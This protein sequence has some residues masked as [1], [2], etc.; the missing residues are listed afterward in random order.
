MPSRPDS[1]DGSAL[2]ITEQAPT[3]LA[4]S[5]GIYNPATELEALFAH[6]T[7][8]EIENAPAPVV[9]DPDESLTG[10]LETQGSIINH[11]V[12]SPGNSPGI[13]NHTG[14]FTQSGTMQIEI[15]GLTPGPGTPTDNGYDQLNVS[16]MLTLGGTLEIRLIND[17]VPELGDTFEFITAG[18]ISGDFDNFTGMD[19]GDGLYLKPVL[20][21]GT[22][23]LEVAELPGGIVADAGADQDELLAFLAGKSSATAFAF[24]GTI[25][26]SGFLHLS[27]SFALDFFVNESVEVGTGIPQNIGGALQNYP[28]LQAAANAVLA[29]PGVTADANF[30]TISNWQLNI[31]TVGAANVDAFVGFG[32]PDFSQ[33]LEGQTSLVG[34][35]VHDLDIGL[36]FGSTDPPII[37]ALLNFVGVA[38]HAESA[39][40][41]GAGAVSVI[42]ND[43]DLLLNDNHTS[44]PLDVGTAVVNW[45]SSYPDD[46]GDGNDGLAIA[47][48]ELDAQGNEA[49]VYL[50]H[51]GEQRVSV[52][53]GDMRAEIFDFVHLQGSFAFSKGGRQL[54]DITT[55]FQQNTADLAGLILEPVVNA[56]VE[57]SLATRISDTFDLIY[58]WEVESL[59]IGGHGIKAFIGFGD[60]DFDQ[61]LAGQSGLYGAYIDNLELG[62]AL[63][64]S[65]FPIEFEPLRQFVAL[66]ATADS[67][68]FT[69]NGS[70]LLQIEAEGIDLVLNDNFEAWPVLDSPAILNWEESFP[71]GDDSDEDPDGFVIATGA[72]DA[73]GDPV[74]V[75]LDMDGEQRRRVSIEHAVVTL[76]DFVHLEGSIFFEQ[77]PA[78]AATVNTRLPANL[79]PA[80]SL[81]AP[82]FEALELAGFEVEDDLSS[83][84]N[85]DLG[86]LVIGGYD[87]SGFVG[88][89]DPDFDQPL[90]GQDLFG[91]G[92]QGVTFGFGQFTHDLP[93][94][95]LPNFTAFKA[96][97][98]EVAFYGGGEI[99]KVQAQD[100]TIEINTG[101]EWPGG[102]GPPVIDWETSF[103]SQNNGPVGF[104]VGTGNP[105]EPVY[106]DF[107]GDE[108][109]SV[110]VGNAEVTLFDFV[111]L[112]GSLAFS[113]GGRHLVDITTG[114]QQNMADLAGALL[115]PVVNAITEY[116]LAAR[117]SETFDMI[118]DW[119]VESL[120]IGGHGIKAFVGFG[121]PDFNQPL[122]GQSGLYGAYVDNL[123]LGLAL[124]NSTFPIEFAPL[125]QF[126]SL[127]ATAD[128][129]GFTLNGSD[130]LKVEAQG[131]ELVLNDNFEAWPVLDSPA[132]LNWEES[133]LDGEDAD[134]EPDGL[135]IATGA[136]D[137]NGDPIEVVLDM[138]GEQRRRVSI[139]HAVVTL[140]DFV[141]L[142]GSIFFE[143]GPAIAAAVNTRLPADLGPLTNAIAPIFQSLEAAGFDV[144]DDLSGF[145]NFDL[146]S[147][148]IGGY[149]VSGFVGFGDPDFSQPLAG[150]DLF[151]FGIQ[152]VTFGFGQFTHD[153]PIDFLPNFTAFK[154]TAEEFAFYGGGDLF[155]LTAQDITVEVNTG[156]AW[157]GG[158]GPPVIDWELSFPSENGGPVGFE[159][160]T[161]NPDEPVYFDFPGEELIGVS[162]GHASLTLL[163]VVHVDGSFSFQKGRRAT[164][165]LDAPDLFALDQRKEVEFITIGGYDV[166]AFVGF[167]G[168]Y[169]LNDGDID[170]NG[171][172]Q[173][174][175][176]DYLNDDAIG[177]SINSLDFGIAIAKPTNP[178]DGAKYFALAAS[179]DDVDFVG[180]DA[181][182]LFTEGVFIE[183]NNVSNYVPGEFSLT[184]PAINFASSFADTDGFQI[185]T[186]ATYTD[187]NTNQEVD[188]TVPLTMESTLIHVRAE[189]LEMEIADLL[190]VTG[191]FDFSFGETRTVTL[192]NDDTKEVT[193]LTVTATDV[194]GFVGLDGPYWRD[195]NGDKRII[196]DQNV[197]NHD[198][199]DTDAFGLS[200]E[201]LDFGMA[202]MKPTNLFDLSNYIAVKARADRL[203]L[204]GIDFVTADVQ[205]AKVEF[206]LVTGLPLDPLHPVDFLASFPGDT[207]QED[208][209]LLAVGNDSL[210]LDFDGLFARTEFFAELGLR[211]PGTDVN[212]CTLRGVFIAEVSLE[213][214]SMFL[215]AELFIGPSSVRIFDFHAIGAMVIHSGG[216]AFDIDV[217]I[218]I[219]TGSVLEGIFTF[220]GNARVV[221]NS[222]G[223]DQEVEIPEQFI[224]NLS[225]KARERLVAASDGSGQA[226]P[227]TAGA[228]QFDGSTGPAGPYLVVVGDGVF[229]L[230][231]G[232]LKI[233]SSFRL[234]VSTVKFQIHVDGEFDFIGF[235]TASGSA[236]LLITST[237]FTIAA[238]I[239]FSLGDFLEVSAAGVISIRSDGL[240]F[241]AQVAVDADIAGIIT[242]VAEGELQINTTGSRV[243][244]YGFD[245]P[246]NSFLLDL[247]G[248]L[249]ILS[250]LKFDASFKMVIR[251]YEWS[252][253][254]EASIDFF[255]IGFLSIAGGLNS[256]GEFEIDVQGSLSIGVPGFGLFGDGSFRISYTDSNGVSLFGTGPYILAFH[257][258]A[259]L[260]IELFG[261]TLA[262]VRMIFD[263]TSATGKISVTAIFSI[264]FGL[265]SIDFETTFT[266]GYL[267][268]PPPPV[269]ADLNGGVLYLNVGSR[270]PLRNYDSENIHELYVI[271]QVV[272]DAGNQVTRV[273]G[274]GISQNYIGV[275]K[276]VGDFGDGIDYVEVDDSVTVPVEFTMGD[277]PDMVMHY[278][279]G[280]AT[281][282]TG[283]WFSTV[284]L[285]NASGTIRLGDNPTSRQAVDDTIVLGS[286]DVTLT[287][288]SGPI[289]RDKI[290][291]G[292]DLVL[293]LRR[294]DQG[295]SG[296]LGQL[297]GTLSGSGQEIKITNTR[298][299]T[300]T[301]TSGDDDISF[302]GVANRTLTISDFGG[303]DSITF[304][305]MNASTL[306]LTDSAGSNDR[307]D[308][309]I[310]SAGQPLTVNY[311]ETRVA[312]GNINWSGFE[313]QSLRNTSSALTTIVNTDNGGVTDL[314][315][316]RFKLTTGGAVLAN[317]M[318]TGGITVVAPSGFTAPEVLQARRDGVIDISTSN[319][320]AGI[321]LFD[322]LYVSGSG[323][324]DGA[325]AGSIKLVSRD[326]N[327]RI[328][329]TY[330]HAAG[331]HLMI[332]GRQITA[333]IRSTVA[334]LTAST[335]GAG[336]GADIIV[337]E[338]DDL[339]VLGLD[340]TP[341]GSTNVTGIVSD[342][343]MIDVQM[344]QADARLTLVSGNIITR[345]AAKDIVINAGDID[346][347][348]GIATV[349][350]TGELTLRP[351]DLSWNY[352]IGSTA[353]NASGG[354][355]PRGTYLN[356]MELSM[357]DIEALAN[358]FSRVT[359]GR[360]NAGNHMTIGDLE[361]TDV[362][363]ASGDPRHVEAQLKDYF[364]FLTDHLEIEGDA[365]AP[366]DRVDF[367]ARIV[368]VRKANFHTPNGPPH[369]GVTAKEI[370]FYVG[371]QMIHGGWLI[372]QNSVF[373]TATA[374][375][376]VNYIV[377]YSDGPN[378]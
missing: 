113:M 90:S 131:I 182:E 114:L 38:G 9:L 49:F 283:P 200:I 345:A 209:L 252:V 190:F 354:D 336:A 26:V 344:F 266:I 83:F 186:G 10:N 311:G 55:G 127:K 318:H 121:D 6:A 78:I 155:E 42:A 229:T 93:I 112:Q 23:R 88:F 36:A 12:L 165:D 7:D 316:V 272:D 115:Q 319:T 69:L 321:D 196:T 150:Q 375:I 260:R 327:I 57:N 94:E 13:I 125:E 29:V 53:V 267:R 34:L 149:N 141:H 79:G 370:N 221:V 270:G 27:G 81:I 22:Y 224:D 52:S 142:E 111:H 298:I 297:G 154:A 66:K 199:P 268:L 285:T 170:L 145:S 179:A 338:T 106:F 146:G 335:T 293:D 5:A 87:V 276:I 129:A 206:N 89:G 133:F 248:E 322:D 77:G 239:E 96:E 214:F 295:L 86:S 180:I 45:A 153:L 314:Q 253:E 223:L 369:S 310:N 377:G 289:G 235:V 156:D 203:H 177:F 157:P 251:D 250:V 264:D 262:E 185:K 138:D 358:G 1:V 284:E 271:K 166:N 143:Q 24:A 372:A 313:E 245:I 65:T 147:L 192:S 226:Y 257:G 164:V 76:L 39:Q 244:A 152:G 60:P 277:D 303:S 349:Q 328:D 195:T 208:G 80:A 171:D 217:D 151:G 54:I 378:S 332:S 130:L 225:D 161:G 246:A 351:L 135:A 40:L 368:E 8:L 25:S 220:E 139:E 227:V 347:K 189:W 202:V 315:S 339:D 104:E 97:V 278:G 359:I 364:V 184:K 176:E 15:G 254:F 376:G 356:A 118:F 47:T 353:E 167:N 91:F 187:P 261:F 105:D 218:S 281:I 320:G 357:R 144:E 92:I 255:G 148:V 237:E 103:P 343:G 126:V 73:N 197:L 158:L 44:W 265:F 210:L 194:F 340:L 216:F 249:A 204:V 72:E 191:G 169:H 291:N 46:D 346:F 300:M 274:Q 101:D 95:S 247:H 304:D 205:D 58:D 233:T 301:L 4:D 333:P 70:D 363:H 16:G 299:D 74:E 242:I 50:N 71:D 41:V 17:F 110:A 61:P 175:E 51:G 286:G 294:A 362:L 32:T 231:G 307:F 292:S 68:G 365:Q 84:S 163:D 132:I 232:V 263:Y 222:T 334:G 59:L 67:A 33:P 43:L 273:K 258:E 178:L 342:F 117:V 162:I 219:G 120:L 312:S 241:G 373:I 3:P 31:F 172:G 317:E 64:N 259:G 352:R 341:D 330:F 30:S 56:I 168:P 48:G 290:S 348:A 193:M 37:P 367:H 160:G 279:S 282:D 288:G 63:M 140:L 325:G 75:V 305:Q 122:A 173:I 188:I 11:G 280:H 309:G 99:W 159:V 14:D 116:G 35:I 228:P 102:F 287:Y 123:E 28:A 136:E 331:S 350:G 238:S 212:L 174:T 308:A 256:E 100:V 337:R 183:V 128:S 236:D 296:S 198:T 275:T 21:D 243:N 201:N 366:N 108:L 98:E 213:G 269:L 18:S 20:D 371:E 215:D 207:G 329:D 181:L 355:W 211:V 230:A 374:T 326:G 302:T 324:L 19:L 2:E 361:Y 323:N 119:E 134:D 360:T 82:I 107:P 306:N 109:I 62:L 240:V 124:M 234:E 137:A 85:F